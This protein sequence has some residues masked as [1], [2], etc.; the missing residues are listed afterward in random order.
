MLKDEV[1]F[2]GMRVFKV[3]LRL[4][5]RNCMFGY[6]VVNFGFFKFGKDGFIGVFNENLMIGVIILLIFDLW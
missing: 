3:I 1:F 6:E 2:I 5:Y 4:Y